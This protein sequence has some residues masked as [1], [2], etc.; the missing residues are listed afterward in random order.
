MLE[1]S[2]GVGRP[3][4]PLH[5]RAVRAPSDGRDSKV[6]YLVGLVS[7]VLQ[8]GVRLRPPVPARTRWR[9]C[10]ASRSRTARCRCR[11]GLTAP[12]AGAKASDLW[13]SVI[14]FHSVLADFGLRPDTGR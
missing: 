13:A 12:T 11:L 10:A 9:C 5:L 8:A 2:F 6:S 4:A 3:H 14:D 1:H 7:R